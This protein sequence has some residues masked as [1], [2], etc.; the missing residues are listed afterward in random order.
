MNKNMTNFMLLGI[1][2]LFGLLM[3]EVAAQSNIDTVDKYA[4]A[5]NTGWFNF[6]PTHGGVTVYVDHL[7]GYVWSGNIGWIKLGSDSGGDA[8]PYTNNDSTDWG[9]NHD[10]AGN[11]S[12]YAWSENLGWINFNPSHSQVTI[13]LT[14]GDFAGY[15]YSS[16]IGWINF[17]DVVSQ[18]P[19]YKV[20]Y[21]VLPPPTGL[22]A[23][24][25]SQ[26]QIDLDWTDN[27]DN[28]TGFIIV[29]D[30]TEIHTTVANEVSYSDDKGLECNTTHEYTVKATNAINNSVSTKVIVA[31]T[32]PCPTAPNPPTDLIAT[33]ASRTQIN[34]TWKDNSD[35][36]TGFKIDRRIEA[37][38]TL[39]SIDT[40]A[41]V[42][43]Y[44]DTGLDC[45]TTYKYSVQAINSSG[46]STAIET[47]AIT[48]KCPT[49]PDFPNNFTAIADSQT[50]INLTWK[51]NSENETGFKIERDGILI[52]TTAANATSFEDTTGLSCG[53]SYK[54][55]L[56]AT[57]A[58]GDSVAVKT[59]ATTLACTPTAP[60]A[61]TAETISKN[62]VIFSWK[63]NSS[64]ETGFKIER[65]DTLIHT[66]APDVT[67]F[68]ESNLTCGTTYNYAVKATAD[69]DSE[70][71]TTTV[72]TTACPPPGEVSNLTAK[73]I[74]KNQITLTWEDNSDNETGFEI[75]RDGTL[76]QTTAANATSFKD[77]GLSCGTFY[78]YALKD[79]YAVKATADDES[80]VITMTV[81][82]A[83]C[84]PYTGGSSGAT[85]CSNSTNEISNSC[86]G[87]GE[88]FTDD[89]IIGEHASVSDVEFEGNVTNYGW[90]SNSK[91]TASATLSGGNLTGTI[92][93]E[94]T[95]ADV[96][97]VGIELEGGTLSGTITNN[98]QVN[99]VIANVQ[100]AE[101]AILSGGKAGGNVKCLLNGIAQDVQLVDGT[102]I[103]GCNL[104]GEIDGTKKGQAKIGEANLE[105][106]TIL[107][108]VCLTP[109]VQY[110]P[111]TVTLGAGVIT[112]INPD[113]PTIED[114]CIAPSQI[115][116]WDG[117]DIIGVEPKAFSTF[118]AN[119]I[120]N[121]LP[122]AISSLNAKQL[123][124]FSKIGLS[125]MTI[126]QFEHLLVIS[127][128][129]LN[130]DNMG[131]FSPKVVKQFTLSHLNALNV[132]QFKQMLSQDVSKLFTNF[133]GEAI[134]PT[135]I[136]KLV[137]FGWTLDLETGVLT[138]PKNAKITLRALSLPE[139]LPPSV[140]LPD[141]VDLDKGFGLGGAGNPV[142]EDLAD[143]LVAANLGNLAPSQDDNGIL[144]IK[145]Y[146]DMEIRYS[147]IPDV[148]DVTQI[149]FLGNTFGLSVGD[150]GF[151]H[152]TT[153]GDVQIPFI[154]ASKNPIALS[155][156]I[157]GGK[158]VM[159]KSGDVLIEP[160]TQKRRGGHTRRVV[161]FDP[162]IMPPPDDLCVEITPLEFVCDFD[163]APESQRPGIHI[164][165]NTIGDEP[166]TAI[167]PD[168]SSQ[169][170]YPTVLYPDIFIEE[171]WKI[172]G[173]ENVIFNSNGTFSVL[174]NGSPYLLSHDFKVQSRKLAKK[175]KV[176]PSVTFNPKVGLVKYMIQSGLSADAG[177]VLTFNLTV[178]IQD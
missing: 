15:A 121:I 36:E 21:K 156:M 9:V 173:V 126:A 46:N 149:D 165:S 27:S 113:N 3:Q 61:L 103:I 70:A 108:H 141:M 88:T 34:L 119:H 23:V 90:I 162:F 169:T 24:A 75:E 94:G 102:S 132:E 83:D 64:N 159:G 164:N 68:V 44:N 13:D 84:S 155:N 80:E 6:R 41:N 122:D 130:S 174:F 74:S 4:W 153:T 168:G 161:I 139:N 50:Q 8:Q 52:K 143:A 42:T 127:L 29:R 55:A 77:T 71:T 114:F 1:I 150:G 63:D 72:T 2:M 145:D 129:G 28:E 10:G 16:N 157:G 144:H 120:A 62:Q 137:P 19:A 65:D 135:D 38:G 138:A 177:E 175:E 104:V 35:D 25:V 22:G 128:G 53:T 37:D 158:V 146:E 51:A 69:D 105:P 148:D 124:E 60:T 31:T 112:P 56:K 76:I 172:A 136:E 170:I 32:K 58:D 109:T 166:N 133:N 147:F 131:G 154:P 86:G 140:T 73:S 91:L 82:T 107:S 59:T 87:G 152:L 163:N 142:V 66:T 100:L 47:T 110:D 40:V 117:N 30:G 116:M 81:T 151:Y 39:T 99:G 18:E 134:N 111:N 43:T 79:E 93:N 167:Y 171:S 11:L 89:I 26:T 98:S 115:F 17:R 118:N 67:R 48:A 160:S 85:S 78:D 95:I 178:S 97:F 45:G 54:Y 57:N 96:N 49:P 123:A 33:S 101:N 20:T 106:D 12:G 7:E 176:K 14:T 5:E 92:T 125:G